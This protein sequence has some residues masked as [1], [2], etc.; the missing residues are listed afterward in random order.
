MKL[1]VTEADMEI[2]GS[3]SQES[4]GILFLALCNLSLG[5]EPF[6]APDTPGDVKLAYQVLNKGILLTKKRAEAG[7]QGG[8]AKASKTHFASS[9]SVAKP[10]LLDICHKQ[11]PSKTQF[12]RD[13][14]V[15][16]TQYLDN[17]KIDS[18]LSTTIPQSLDGTERERKE[19]LKER[20]EKVEAVQKPTSVL[21]Y[22]GVQ[23]AFA[24]F[25]KMRKTIKKPLTDNAVVRAKDKLA[26]MSGGDA[27]KAIRILHNTTDHCWQDLYA[28]RKDEDTS[29]PPSYS[30]S[31]PTRPK[32]NTFNDFDQRKPGDRDY[33]DLDAM[34]RKEL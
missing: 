2:I 29:Q 17:T 8:L 28:P 19:K 23:E 11:N 7:K 21:D 18:P 25:V 12:A 30:P 26:K 33:V 14:P 22:P 32:P 4:A 20:Q 6:F 5:K 3:M 9:K 31:Q 1:N 24:E 13:L 10:D 16:K 15:A 34:L 27:E